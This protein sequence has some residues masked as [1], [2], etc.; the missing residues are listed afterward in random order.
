[1]VSYL[2]KECSDCGIVFDTIGRINKILSKYGKDQYLNFSYLLKKPFPREKI[3]LLIRYKDILE[4]CSWNTKFYE[5]YFS[6]P[7][8]IS[9]VKVLTNGL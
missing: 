5:P 4:N 8:I 6:T 9:R 1:M 7:E 2:V 3:K